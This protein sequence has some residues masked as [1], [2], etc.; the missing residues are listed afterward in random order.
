MDT[1]PMGRSGRLT[2]HRWQGVL[3]VAISAAGFASLGLFAR[4][5]TASGASLLTVLAL[6]FVL[7]GAILA[8]VLRHR[9]LAW[10][11]GRELAGLVLLGALGY[12]AQSF[13]FFS[14]LN[15]L[16]VGLTVLLLY[17]HPA[18]V[19]LA[20]AAL[21]RQRLS[22]RKAALAAASFAGILL[23][24]SN[25]LAGT[26]V[27][28]AFGIGAAL[29]Y[30]NY[31]LVGEHLTPRTGVIPA[32]TVIVL[33]A[34]VMFSLGALVE[35]VRWPGTTGGWLAV[36]GIAVLGTSLAT[37]TFF[38]GVQRIGAGDAATLSTLEPV[39]A[40]VLAFV[41]L[42]EQLGAVQLAGALLVI[43]SAAM[44]GRSG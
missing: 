40:L 16:T 22:L 37:V 38:A 3:L 41:F 5:A 11:R 28:L 9:R 8:L 19:L 4:V 14:A 34:A 23:T 15:H 12:T 42:G 43:A 44:L 26:P 30:T 32:A 33:S 24:V 10:P 1:V 18:L 20:G 17:L 35:G 31:I 13:C 21:G 7:A 36:A 27:G 6:R 39:V 2:G 29:I 25:D